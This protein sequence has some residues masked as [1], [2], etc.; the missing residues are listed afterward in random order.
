MTAKGLL[1]SLKHARKTLKEFS[2]N[3]FEGDR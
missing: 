3:L 2:T 1:F